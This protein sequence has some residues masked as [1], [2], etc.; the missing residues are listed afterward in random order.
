M[1]NVL[2]D[3]YLFNIQSYLPENI[4]L[5]TF[6]PAQGFP[7]QLSRAHALLVRTVL[8]VGKQTIPHIPAQ[9][10]FV[11]T[12]SA[13]SDHVNIDYLTK[14]GIEFTN[15]AGCNARSVAEYVA[16]ALLLWGEN[17]KKDLTSLTLGI[18]GVGE[19]GSRVSRLMGKLGISTVEF[20][21]PREKREAAFASA[22]C[23][24]LLECDILSF[25]TPLTKDG[26]YPTYH[27]LDEEKLSGQPFELI[28]NTSRG[29]VIDEQAVLQSKAKGKIRDI[30]IDVWEN[31]PE[32][33]LATARQ[34]FIKTPHIAGYSVQAKENASRIVAN[35]MLN[36]FDLPVKEKDKD[37][38]SR[39]LNKD[40]A[41]FESLSELL[42]ELHPIKE[43]E[44]ELQRIIADHPE[45]RGKPFNRLRAEFPLRQEF[46][47]TYLP[48]SYF[49]RFPILEKL[50]FSEIE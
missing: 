33:S 20:D 10:E 36:H 39:I 44:M 8:P 29:G 49:D 11:G 42:T 41:T 48:Q 5:I 14:H 40:I 3:Q 2:A 15:A 46:A 4:N 25:H 21:P 16:V 26:D 30:I 24:E 35:A 38:H 37:Q 23:T 17:R 47:N 43:Y 27:W 6:D 50:G 22:S 1:I 12:A 45:E 32:F 9:L 19:V 13:G 34:A 18:I 28:I 31:E 7:K